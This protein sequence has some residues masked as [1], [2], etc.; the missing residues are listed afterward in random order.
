MLCVMPP[1]QHG[2]PSSDLNRRPDQARPEF[3]PGVRQ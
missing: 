2:E 1:V 3:P